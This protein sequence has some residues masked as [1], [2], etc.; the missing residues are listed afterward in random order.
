[1]SGLDEVSLWIGRSPELCDIVV[2]KPWVSQCHC[3]LT[4]DDARSMWVVHDL[5]SRNGTAIIVEGRVLGVPPGSAAPV[6]HGVLLRLGS[7]SALLL[8]PELIALA[9]QAKTTGTG[10]ITV[11]A[12]GHTTATGEPLERLVV[13]A[14]QD[15]GA[16]P[17]SLHSASA[18][19]PN[20]AA[21]GGVRVRCENV[22]LTVITADGAPRTL[23]HPMSLVLEPGTVTGLMGLSGAGKTALLRLLAGVAAPTSGSLVT[24]SKTGLHGVPA[25]V[26]QADALPEFLTVREHLRS[27]AAIRLAHLDPDAIEAR[28]A[29]CVEALDLGPMADQRIG[30]PH[31]G[32]L[33]G[34]QRRRVQLAT[35]LLGAPSLLLLDEPTSGLSSADALEI[36]HLLRRIATGGTTVLVSL[37]Q[38]SL[39]LYRLLDRVVVLFEGELVYGGRAWPDAVHFIAGP[40]PDTPEAAH[41]DRMIEALAERKR[42]AQQQPSP[43][44]SV[45]DEARRLAGRFA[46]HRDAVGSTS[47]D[48]LRPSQG[49]S[50]TSAPFPRQVGHALHKAAA[51]LSRRGVEVARDRATVLTLVL[52]APVIGLVLLLLFGRSLAPAAET[53]ARTGQ[54]NG[55]LFLMVVVSI[56]F[57]CS[58]AARELVAERNWWLH[59]NRAGLGEGPYLLARFCLLLA[60]CL[61]QCGVLL[62]IVRA[63]AGL[64]GPWP[65]QWLTLWLASAGGIAMGLL[66]SAFVRRPATALSMIPLVL[67][68]QIALGGLLFPGW[69]QPRAVQAVGDLTVARWGFEA[70][71]QLERGHEDAAWFAS[72]CG[73]YDSA[74]NTCVVTYGDPPCVFRE[75][76]TT[77][78][79]LPVRTSLLS[80]PLVALAC[81]HFCDQLVAGEPITTLDSLLGVDPGDP[82]RVRVAQ[83]LAHDANGGIPSGRSMRTAQHP[84]DAVLRIWGILAVGTAALLLLTL[85]RLRRSAPGPRR[86]QEP[87]ALDS[88]SPNPRGAR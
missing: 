23:L 45:R 72:A 29:G 67:I 26:P 75:H 62:L 39:D 13:D 60:V 59:E 56:W 53:V 55:L 22:T 50:G 42:C 28:V 87:R 5:E 74:P 38:P 15:E 57:G 71:L 88:D 14:D 58:I 78:C 69:S 65:A 7:S 27:T 20:A 44:A 51:L 76:G 70:M 41:P 83:A 19:A 2:P 34:G 80:A 16:P 35:E 40:E 9:C 31:V 46:A 61:I 73:L 66:L 18:A 81:L 17:R 10:P 63:G 54:A 77:Q 25:F 12:Q 11:C 3:A 32:G 82:M 33:S 6:G 43:A 4:W 36:L 24:E 85:L 47:P 30:D 79:A 68:P 37:H 84:L 52:Q 64:E 1:M 21:P 86:I 8:T 49:D 48:G